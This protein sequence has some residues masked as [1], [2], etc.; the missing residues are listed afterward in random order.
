MASE[1]MA[2]TETCQPASSAR[3]I[4]SVRSAGSQFMTLP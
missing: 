3:A 1:L 2:W 4:V